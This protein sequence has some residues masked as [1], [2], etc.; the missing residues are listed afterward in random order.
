MSGIVIVLGVTI[1]AVQEPRFVFTKKGGLH[2]DSVGWKARPIIGTHE[3]DQYAAR[4]ALP[5]HF[6]ADGV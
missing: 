6:E 5:D 2:T 4:D 1:V 3:S